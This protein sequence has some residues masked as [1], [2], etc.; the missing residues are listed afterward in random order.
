MSQMILDRNDVM[1]R[2]YEID[3]K[4]ITKYKLILKTWK[5][6]C[7]ELKASMQDCVMITGEVNYSPGM[8]AHQSKQFDLEEAIRFINRVNDQLFIS[9]NNND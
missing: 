4:G 9:T 3:R 5:T 6:Y 7:E 1:F 8:W 2:D